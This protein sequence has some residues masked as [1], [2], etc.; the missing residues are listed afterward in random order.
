[1]R[2]K[3]FSSLPQYKEYNI[4]EGVI[5]LALIEDRDL[6][7]PIKVDTLEHYFKLQYR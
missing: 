2:F 3:H 1:M 6:L 4:S 5:F 7:S